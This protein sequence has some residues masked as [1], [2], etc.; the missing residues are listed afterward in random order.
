MHLLRGS[1][2]NALTEA[3]SI[4]L[5]GGER[6]SVKSQPSAYGGGRSNA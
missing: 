1:L 5:P 2:L 3:F 4:G 6:S